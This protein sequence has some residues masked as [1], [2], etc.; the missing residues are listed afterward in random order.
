LHGLGIEQV[1]GKE[2][3]TGFQVGREFLVEYRRDLWQI[4][5]YNLQVGV[6]FREGDVVVAC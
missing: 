1:V 5:D 6:R 2:G 3:D 4:L